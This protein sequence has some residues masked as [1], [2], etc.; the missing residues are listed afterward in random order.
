[1]LADKGFGG[2]TLRAV[3][4]AMNGSTGMLMHYF[5]TKRALIAHAL[6]LLEVRTRNARA[7]HGL[8]RDCRRCAPYCW[9]SCR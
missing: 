7:A 1:M 4:A 9:T 8:P 2:L 6:D 3:A 5:P